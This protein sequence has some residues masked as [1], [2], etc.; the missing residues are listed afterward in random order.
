MILTA[1]GDDG[2]KAAPPIDSGSGSGTDTTPPAVTFHQ[3]EQLA[4]PAINEALLIT[5]AYLDGYN[6]TAPTFA[7]VPPDTLTA[8]VGEAKTV[9][10]ALY[11]GGCLLDGLAGVTAATGVKPAGMTCHAIGT[12]LFMADGVTLTP[13]SVTAS[14]AY[15]DKVFAQFIPDVLRIDTAAASNYLT[16]CG[17]NGPLLC[18]GRGLADD[19][20]DITYNYLLNGADN[21]LNP[22]QNTTALGKQLIA[23]TSDGVTYS[24]TAAKNVD[25]LSVP[26]PTNAQQGHPDFLTTFPY[27]APPF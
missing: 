22:A 2:N 9:L 20:V 11:L 4:R 14:Q 17:G 27:S 16:L 12:A 25:S 1:C 26:D 8:V 18:G 19:V 7:G 23:L 10:K 3:V 15:A 21:Y 13:A 5:T 6:A 24:K